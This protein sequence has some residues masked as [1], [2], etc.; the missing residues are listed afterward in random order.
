M[1][2]LMKEHL[3]TYPVRIN[4]FKEHN[5]LKDKLLDA[6]A[7]QENVENLTGPNNNITRCDWSDM[8][9]D[10]SREWLGLMGIAL[11]E[12]LDQWAASLDYDTFQI[13]EIW[14]QQ[15]NTGSKH[16]WH[17]HG[18]NFTNVYFLDLPKDSPKTQWIDPVS[19]LAHEFDVEEGDIITFPSWL[20]HRAPENQSSEMKTIISW[21][22]DVMITDHYESIN[23][24]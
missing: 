17:V 23:T 8:R 2:V 5:E 21:N 24:I 22:M 7:R 15:Y 4:K 1:E 18:A 6:I 20:I 14:F 12:H 13:H 19:K 3:V 10:R 16:A 9:F 11:H